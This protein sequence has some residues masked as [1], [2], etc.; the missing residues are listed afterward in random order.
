MHTISNN[1]NHDK[2]VSYVW[3]DVLNEVMRRKADGLKASLFNR[4][5]A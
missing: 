3:S 2:C 1:E 4:L 5:L